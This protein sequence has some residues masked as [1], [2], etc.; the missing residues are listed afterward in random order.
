MEGCWN[1]ESDYRLRDVNSGAI[2]QVNRWQVCLD[3]QGRGNQTLRFSD[4]TT[5]EAPV[6]ASFNSAG[7]LVLRDQGNVQCSNGTQ[8]FERV[9]T[10]SLNSQ[11]Q[12]DCVT[13]QRE[14]NSRSNVRLR[15]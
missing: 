10:C 6:A 7:R 14:T 8:I 2:V 11:G 12:A 13:T 5:C 3:A 1:L 9:T 15:R 4:G